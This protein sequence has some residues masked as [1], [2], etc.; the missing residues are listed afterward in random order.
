MSEEVFCAI[1]GGPLKEPDW[2]DDDEDAQSDERYDPA[3]LQL[4]DPKLEW[5]NTWRVIGAWEGT[6][7]PG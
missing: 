1:C 7:P 6:G 3:V 2:D 4:D 5:L